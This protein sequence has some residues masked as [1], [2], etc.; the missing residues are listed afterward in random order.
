MDMPIDC[1]ATTDADGSSLFGNLM[2]LGCSLS[3][4]TLIYRKFFIFYVIYSLVFISFPF[5]Y[6][7]VRFVFSKCY[8][9]AHIFEQ[10]MPSDAVM[11]FNDGQGSMTIGDFLTTE[12]KKSIMWLT[13]ASC[14]IMYVCLFI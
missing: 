6:P 4:F 14:L 5:I 10:G 1:I 8:N 13:M 2:L 9:K 11:R 12:R 3:S 7:W